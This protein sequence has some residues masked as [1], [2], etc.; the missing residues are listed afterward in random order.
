M[1]HVLPAGD[2]LL[3]NVVYYC[4]TAL[5]EAGTAATPLLSDQAVQPQDLLLEPQSILVCFAD[6]VQQSLPILSL[7]F[8]RQKQTLGWLLMLPFYQTTSEACMPSSPLLAVV[9]LT[10]PGAAE[11]IHCSTRGAP[12]AYSEPNETTS[13][14][15]MAESLPAHPFPVIPSFCLRGLFCNTHSP[16][17]QQ[18]T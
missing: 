8:S 6:H 13:N 1:C 5:L 18:H 9:A 12:G 17:R 4:C 16:K 3:W 15:P 11:G 14:L 10:V 2:R 7:L